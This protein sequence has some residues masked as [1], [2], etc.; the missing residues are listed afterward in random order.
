MKHSPNTILETILNR[1]DAGETMAQIQSSL[2]SHEA[3]SYADIIDFLQAQQQTIAPNP[4]HLRQALVQSA[5]LK[6][7]EQQDHW[8]VL[9]KIFGNWK[10]FTGVA[11][12][13]FGIGFLTA[14]MWLP[15]ETIERSQSPTIAL[16]SYKKA[17]PAVARVAVSSDA[18]AEKALK[19]E[20]SGDDVALVQALE[21]DFDVD[22]NDFYDTQAEFDSFLEDPL[23]SSLN[24]TQS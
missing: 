13:L 12:S 17:V 9:A 20:S 3:K 22:L 15:S 4:E 24:S 7:A 10:P 14:N 6:Q 16:E 1:L 2:K 5:L 11:M 23:F 19:I 21:A 8:G 18:V